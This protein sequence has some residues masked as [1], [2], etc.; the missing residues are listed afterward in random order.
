[1]QIQFC[2]V[3]FGTADHNP[4]V[5]K[6]SAKQPDQAV[7]IESPINRLDEEG[8]T[9]LMQALN[10]GNEA[11]ALWWLEQPGIDVNISS[12]SDELDGQNMRENALHLAVEQGYTR[13]VKRLLEKMSPEAINQL[14]SN[15]M[16][17][18]AIAIENKSDVVFQQ[19]LSHPGIDVNKEIKMYEHPVMY[20]VNLNS[21][22]LLFSFGGSHRRFDMAQALLD[23]PR[24]NLDLLK[25]RKGQYV[26]TLRRLEKKGKLR[27]PTR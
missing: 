23:H 10:K 25:N 4:R 7:A 15:T 27:L 12:G 2:A 14:D 8:Y 1:M 13:V 9:P 6:G 5:P 16:T 18:L 19:L 22:P 3:R 26:W 11:L 20:A 21:N 17:P 24:T